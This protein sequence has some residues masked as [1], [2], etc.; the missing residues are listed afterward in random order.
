MDDNIT[1]KLE[2]AG[3]D[4]KVKCLRSEEPLYREAADLIKKVH[5]NKTKAVGANA[6]VKEEVILTFDLLEVALQLKRLE[7]KCSEESMRLQ[8]LE[9]ELSKYLNPS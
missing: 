5:K 3:S 9:E 6:G 8:S 4:Y 1:I 2:L 7:S